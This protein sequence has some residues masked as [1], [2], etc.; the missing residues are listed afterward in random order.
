MVGEV[1]RRSF[2]KGSALGS[3]S[4]LLD[5]RAAAAEGRPV[6]PATFGHH[7]W[8]KRVGERTAI[9][10]FCAVGCGVIAAVENGKVTNIEGDPDHPINQ[11]RLCSKGSALLQ[12][13]D[14]PRRQL[15]VLYRAPYATEWQPLPWDE[16]LRRIAARIRATRDAG[17]VERDGGVVV[18]RCESIA[19]MGS[20]AIKNEEAYLVT[21]FCRALGLVYHEHQARL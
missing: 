14:N 17:F 21:K 10:P 15:R 1:S 3:G 19:E 16:A 6:G 2:I 7:R 4:L 13:H 18:N 8:N 9:C 20:S 12:E 5:W 11:G